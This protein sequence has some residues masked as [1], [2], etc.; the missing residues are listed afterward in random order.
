MS[1]KDRAISTAAIYL[2]RERGDQGCKFNY[3]EAEGTKR[4]ATVNWGE[5]SWQR[6]EHLPTRKSFVQD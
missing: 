4:W 5:T 2:C 3:Q 1:F 6:E